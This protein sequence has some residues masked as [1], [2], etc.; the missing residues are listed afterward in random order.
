MRAA[1]PRRPGAT[2]WLTG[3]SGSGKSSIAA[4]LADLLALAG[5]PHYLLDGDELREGLNSDLGFGARDREENVRRAG[6]VALLFARAG[7]LAIVS[8][9]SPYAAGRKAVRA[10]HDEAGVAFL[11]VYV[12]TPLSV[13]EA[14]DPKGLYARARAGEIPAFTGVSDPYEPPEA[15]ELVLRTEGRTAADSARDVLALLSSRR[16][17]AIS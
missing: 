17:L 15:P 11:E 3:L 2:V 1:S 4:A 9:I 6:E 14:R 13:C 16:L 12:A 8:L 10:R 7:Q 5:V